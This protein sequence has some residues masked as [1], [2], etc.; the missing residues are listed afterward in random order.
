MNI[1]NSIHAVKRFM[2]YCDAK[3]GTEIP[4]AVKAYE[5][6]ELIH[7]GKALLYCSYNHGYMQ[8][9]TSIQWSFDDYVMRQLGLHGTYNTNFQ[10]Y[11]YSDG[12]LTVEDG[13]TSIIITKG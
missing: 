7:N 6:S 8:Y 3:D 2:S 10:L 4:V 12:H 9:E 5:N 1:D 11:S 13:N